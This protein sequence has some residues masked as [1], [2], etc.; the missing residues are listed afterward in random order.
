MTREE[1]E[2]RMIEIPTPYMRENEAR[3]HV[4]RLRTDPAHSREEGKVLWEVAEHA[5]IILLR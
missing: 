5:G 3:E 4:H 2:Q 1:R